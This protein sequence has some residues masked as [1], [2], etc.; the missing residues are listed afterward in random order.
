[1]RRALHLDSATAVYRCK[2]AKA[3]PKTG[4]CHCE[5]EELGRKLRPLR[6]T[7]RKGRITLTAMIEKIIPFSAAI[8]RVIGGNKQNKTIHMFSPGTFGDDGA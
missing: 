6:Y 5:S 3:A 2:H 7:A 8:Q 1:M 4:L